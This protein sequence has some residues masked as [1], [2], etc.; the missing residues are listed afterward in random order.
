[1]SGNY[2]GEGLAAT[3]SSLRNP[4]CVWLDTSNNMYICDK[5]NYR[6]RFVVASTTALVTLAGTGSSTAPTEGVATSSNLG[7][8]TRLWMDI[9]SGTVWMA[10]NNYCLVRKYGM[11]SSK[12]IY[13]KIIVAC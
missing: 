1:M 9:S 13:K 8:I 10:E 4:N 3:G 11:S 5:M 12:N 6:L 2:D 7:S